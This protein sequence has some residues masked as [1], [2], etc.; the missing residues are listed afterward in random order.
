MTE[1]NRR[2]YELEYWD[3][4]GVPYFRF[5]GVLSKFTLATEKNKRS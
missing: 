1:V 3:G 4:R 2:K 5:Q